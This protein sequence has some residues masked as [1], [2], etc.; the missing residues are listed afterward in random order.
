MGTEK[1]S[2][3]FSRRRGVR[4]CVTGDWVSWENCAEENLEQMDRP[5]ERTERDSEREYLQCANKLPGYLQ[6]LSPSPS[7]GV[8]CQTCTPSI[9][10][11]VE[12][13]AGGVWSRIFLTE[14]ASVKWAVEII[15]RKLALHHL[16]SAQGLSYSLSRIIRQDPTQ[17]YW[18]YYLQPR[19]KQAAGHQPDHSLNWDLLEN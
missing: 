8:G 5:R 14:T 7:S 18:W 19:Y 2:L 16:W 15:V 9:S 17:W 11:E 12:R 3:L 13:P 10:V 6:T 4:C 1:D